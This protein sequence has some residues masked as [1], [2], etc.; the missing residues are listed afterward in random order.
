MSDL[1]SKNVLFT[2]PAISRL[3]EDQ[4]ISR[5]GQPATG[6]VKRRDG[7]HFPRSMPSYLVEPIFIEGHGAEA[8]IIDLGNGILEPVDAVD[9]N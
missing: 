7:Q 5:F 8:K 3:S 2:A 1:R 9:Q 4:I 6:A